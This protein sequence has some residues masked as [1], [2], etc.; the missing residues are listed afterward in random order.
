MTIASRFAA[1]GRRFRWPSE[2]AVVT[3]VF[4]AYAT[5]LGLWAGAIPA[6]LRQS[7][8]SAAGLG[9]AISLHSGAYIGAMALG[10]QLARVVA[11]RKLILAALALNTL[12]FAAL[13][14]AASPLALTLALSAVGLGAGLLDLAMNTEATAVERDL[15]RPVLLRIHAAASG[16]FGLGAIAGSLIAVGLGPRWCA[17][18]VVALTLPVAFAVR[19]LGPRRQILLTAVAAPAR[20]GAVSGVAILGIVLGVSIGAEMAAQMWSANFLE[21]QAA[22]LA[23]IAGIGAAFFAGCQVVVRVIGDRLR[24]RFGDERVIVFS[25][26]LAAAGFCTV[27]LSNAFAISVAGFALVGLGTAC[28]VP[29]CFALVARRSPGRT[30]AALGVASLVAGLIRLPTPLYL[31]FV[32]ATW[33]DAA[34]FGG[35]ALALLL[36]AALAKRGI[37]GRVG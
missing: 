8:V 30:A 22:D 17:A 12:T 4:F 1:I 6:L 21:R 36:T 9:I 35:I 23:A 15:G 7:G 5:G 28:V 25:L 13:F 33:S 26:L 20:K 18:V 16:A 19:R 24:R 34:A 29:C 32:A 14:S 37:S 27:A 10:G 3:A 11:P 2:R 31:G